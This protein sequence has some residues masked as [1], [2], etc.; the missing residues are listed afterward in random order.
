VPVQRR[1]RAVLA[2][3]AALGAAGGA[4]TAVL[5]GVVAPI[6]YSPLLSLQLFVAVLVG[7]TATW[8]GPAVGVG[9]LAALPSTADAFA[10]AADVDPLRARAVLTAVLLVAAIASR[11]PVRRLLGRTPSAARTVVADDGDASTTSVAT[12][13]SVVLDLRGVTAAYGAV[14]ALDGVDLDLRAGDVHALIGPNGSGKSTALRVAAGVVVP[15]QGRVVVPVTAQSAPR[16]SAARVRAGV[17]RTMQR[18]VSLGDLDVATQVAVGA[19][20]RE[21]TWQLGLRELLNTPGA[22]HVRRGRERAVA[23][24][25]E[26]VGLAGRAT[27]R[28]VGLDSAEQ[29]LLQLARAVATGAPA[30]LVDEPAAGMSAEQR[31][32]LAG[33]LR[34]LADAGHG[35][36][37]VE[38]DMRLVGWV[39]D[40][41][42]VLA[43]GRVLATGSADE[44]RADP[45]VRRAYLGGPVT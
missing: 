42:T 11:G 25:L 43:E 33:V 34:Q 27:A 17:A 40:R 4:G 23:G 6:D 39:A 12:M 2:V 36:L 44:V 1:R 24:A 7:G 31:R 13:D 8:W 18:T 35:V 16:G 45:A 15:Q 32:R 10:S 29:R 14:V 38:H 37:L 21:H 26:I 28:T 20:A 5:L 30:L 41:V 22:L 9:L 3:A 19:R